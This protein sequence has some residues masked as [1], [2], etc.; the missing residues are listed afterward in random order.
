VGLPNFRRVCKLLALANALAYYAAAPVAGRRDLC[1]WLQV[2]PGGPLAPWREYEN[3]LPAC[4]GRT[5][6]PSDHVKIL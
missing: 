4:E 2:H 1:P 5:E 6:F 3:T